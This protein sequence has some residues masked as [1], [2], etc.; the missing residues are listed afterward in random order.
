MAS[1]A[2][3]KV[4]YVFVFYG[5]YFNLIL[6]L[7]IPSAYS[8]LLYLSFLVLY[9]SVGAIDTAIR[10]LT[11]QDRELEKYSRILFVFWLLHPFIFAAMY[12][13]NLYLTQLY[14]TPSASILIGWAG[15]L[16][17][18]IGGVIAV[19]SRVQLGKQGSGRLI[20]QDEHGMVTSGLYNHVRHPMYT[21]GLIGTIAFSM[22][23]RSLLVTILD[24][25]LYFVIFRQRLLKEEEILEQ[26]FG[27]D[28]LEYKRRTKRLIPGVY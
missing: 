24:F 19:L 23:F 10:P 16:V 20:L 26:E 4:V 3:R 21:G 25:A 2:I 14:V 13:E 6:Y 8:N 12:M 22:V 7:L 18:A 17:Y 28:Y 1:P 11:E 9:Y 27:E 5:I 15:L